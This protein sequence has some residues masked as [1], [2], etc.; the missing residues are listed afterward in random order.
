MICQD[1]RFGPKAVAE[2]Q[3]ETKSLIVLLHHGGKQCFSF[4]S[5]TVMLT[6]PWWQSHIGVPPVFN[7]S[8][9][10][11]LLHVSWKPSAGCAFWLVVESWE[12][13]DLL[14][15]FSQQ[16]SQSLV[17]VYLCSRGVLPSAPR[18]CAGRRNKSTTN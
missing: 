7:D 1:D 3:K 11:W 18:G 4:Q 14:P 6:F 9:P 15:T 2:P 12:R 16:F 17:Q 13:P 8:A 5:L 10:K